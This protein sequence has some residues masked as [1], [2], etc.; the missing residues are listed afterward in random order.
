MNALAQW[1]LDGLLYGTALFVFASL[2]SVTALR[3]AHPAT[4]ALLFGLVLIKFVLP[5][6][7]AFPGAPSARPVGTATSTLLVTSSAASDVAVPWAQWLLLAWAAGVV[8][9]AARRG[10]KHR[11][12]LRAL[13]PSS[14]APARVREL[15]EVVG[16]RA[17]RVVFDARGP[18]LVGAWR[19]V[20]VV[21]TE[22]RGVELDAMVLHE[23]MHLRRLD[24]L[25]RALQALVETLFFFWPVVR[26]ASRQL[27]LAREQ[28]CDLAVVEQGLVD[29]AR[30]AEVL[31][32]LG[33]DASPSLA[34]AAQPS[35]LERRIKMVLSAKKLR[36][37]WAGLVVVGLA[38]LA[39]AS[40]SVWSAPDPTSV[41]AAMFSQPAP[42][43]LKLDGSLDELVLTMEMSKRKAALDRCYLDYLAEHPDT[44][45]GTVIL[46]FAISPD[47][48]VD[49]GCQSGG[50]TLPMPV[51]QCITRELQKWQFPMPNDLKTVELE[52]RFDYVPP[53][54][55]S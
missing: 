17:P 28:A 19:P 52:Y 23:L 25:W 6:G 27:S 22:A 31:L 38:G 4:R 14:E 12:L 41:P 26:L 42:V 55:R 51:G 29:R 16:V 39:G 7:F 2:V 48:T 20:L 43:K 45:A 9:L 53:P 5:F 47:G 34:M 37:M 13:G 3:H 32:Q 44:G 36:P 50:T 1:L 54:V 24:P 46:H 11:A 35:H 15:A 40:A 21:P 10:W 30:Y 33:L 8:A 18:C 49:E